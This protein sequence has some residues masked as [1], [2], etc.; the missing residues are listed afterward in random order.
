[1]RVFAPVRVEAKGFLQRKHRFI[2]AGQ[3]LGELETALFSRQSL[4]HQA[5]GQQFV[6]RPK[7]PLSSTYHMQQGEIE[8]ATM[9][10]SDITYRAVPY[11]LRRAGSL[12][13][14]QLRNEQDAVVLEIKPGFLT[15]GTE[16]EM[17]Q[18]ADLPLVVLAYFLVRLRIQRRRRRVGASG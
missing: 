3:V 15:S 14:W 8:W 1:M 4:F 13:A 7:G 16:I 11:Y 2:S 12:G 9:G 5:D 17:L 18:D 6:I 10:R